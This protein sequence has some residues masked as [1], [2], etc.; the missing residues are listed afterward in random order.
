MS[1]PSPYEWC[2]VCTNAII[3]CTCNEVVRDAK[4][5]V[6]MNQTLFSNE[7]L[8]PAQ[9]EVSNIFYA[10]HAQIV[11]ISF[12]FTYLNLQQH[13]RKRRKMNTVEFVCVKSENQEEF[14]N[15]A[16]RSKVKIKIQAKS[17]LYNM[18]QLHFVLGN[19]A[20]TRKQRSAMPTLHIRIGR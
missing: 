15:E 20:F 18:Q 9:V 12:Y 19:R 8:F 4:P 3:N 5:Q 17:L 14:E 6:S 7:T 16:S 1:L 13:A 10:H 2:A 11:K